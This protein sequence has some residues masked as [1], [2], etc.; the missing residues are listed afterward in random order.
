MTVYNDDYKP[1]Y[2]IHPGEYLEDILENR[3]ITN[4][5]FADRVGL[6][7]KAVSQ[8]VNG[9]ALYSPETAIAF[10]KT[11]DIKAEIWLNLADTYQLFIAKSEE[12]RRLE[13]GETAEWVKK[14][15]LSDMRKLNIVP[16]IRRTDILADHILRFFNVS[17]SRRTTNSG[18][19]SSMKLH[20][21]S[22]ME[23]KP[24]SST[25]WET[26]PTKPNWKPIASQPII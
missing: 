9:K 16:N 14:F 10:E 12:R 5:D 22:F 1:D 13:S 2:A 26:I 21:S 23:R 7:E 4:R 24:H 15:P 25:P 3:N 8:I 18:S 17:D 20:T 6:T 11:L 19:H